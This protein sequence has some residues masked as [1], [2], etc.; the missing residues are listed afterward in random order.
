MLS[1][2]FLLLMYYDIYSTHHIGE[3]LALRYLLNQ[4]DK[5]FSA[6]G[7]YIPSIQVQ[8]LTLQ[9]SILVYIHPRYFDK[10]KETC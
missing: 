3:T 1:S 9:N 7:G 8:N 5:Y 4:I 2:L 6:S 10:W